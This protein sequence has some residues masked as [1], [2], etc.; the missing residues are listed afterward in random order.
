MDESEVWTTLETD[1]KREILTQTIHQLQIF[2]YLFQLNSDADSLSEMN[3]DLTL[4]P[5]SNIDVIR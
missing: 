5:L 4:P 2:K 3:L 1:E